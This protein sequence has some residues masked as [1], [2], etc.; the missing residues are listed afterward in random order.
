MIDDRYELLEVIASGG[1]ATVWRGSDTRLDRLVAVKR[2]HPSAPGGDSTPNRMGREARAA[3][4]I[5][6]PNLITVY[7]YGAD[8]DGPYLV[9]ELAEGPTLRDTL[10]QLDEAESLEVG[11]Q[12]AEGLAAVHAGGLV[13]RDVKPA[14]I[15]LSDRGPL[16]TDFGIALDPTSTAEVTADGL[17][18][19][20]PSYAAPEVMAGQRPT[21][22]SD[23]YSLGVV[24]RELLDA[25][26]VAPSPAIDGALESATAHDPNH[27]P[28]AL[29]FAALLRAEAP[30][31][32]FVPG[33][34]VALAGPGEADRTLVM[35]G[36]SRA[37]SPAPREAD[38]GH[39][40]VP[41][42]MLVLG[43]LVLLFAVALAV[44]SGNSPG[45]AAD[46]PSSSSVVGSTL[47]PMSTT[48]PTSTTVA[49]A[50]TTS[51]PADRV[52]E[53]RDRL[54]AILSQPP[55]SDLNEREVDKLMNKI[56]NAIDEARVGDPEKA[57]DELGKVAEELEKKLESG[58]RDA[59]LTE[60][61]R[62]AESLGLRVEVP[63]DEDD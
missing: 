62:L 36:P 45:L 43:V 53:S 22:A 12:V 15:I 59:A 32:N 20:T 33:A 4:A 63:D 60:L 7:D 31:V 56:D 37:S 13:H 42:A 44:S 35:E 28:D 1:M 39:R 57:T 40:R 10:G 14:N 49:P 58:T 41:V 29:S 25:T 30:T 3:A 16:L 46:S 2:P 55:R 52:R 26:G 18:V 19:A 11:A 8:E 24:V 54:E 61:E 9:M 34:P 5:S 51:T 23:V 27:R 21:Q 6:H 38:R 48:V 17:I 47:I 50:T